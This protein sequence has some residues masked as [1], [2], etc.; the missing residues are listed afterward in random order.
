MIV[1]TNLII[2]IHLFICIHII[3]GGG[4]VPTSFLCLDGSTSSD[5]TC[6]T[7]TSG[8]IGTCNC[9]AKSPIN[10]RQGQIC[11]FDSV[12]AVDSVSFTKYFIT[13]KTRKEI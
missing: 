5:C 12:N 8:A 9:I 6:S 2:L 13:S 1:K 3:Y 10:V 7:G 4:P 11:S